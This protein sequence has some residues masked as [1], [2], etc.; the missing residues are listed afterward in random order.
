MTFKDVDDLYARAVELYMAEDYVGA[1]DLVTAGLEQFPQNRR[2]VQGLR[3]M[4]AVRA[5]QQDTSLAILHELIDES[6]GWFG[7][8]FW[9]DEDF[10][11]LRENAEFVRLHA[12]S[13]ERM[14][15]AQAGVKPELTVFE[16]P[17]TSSTP[18]PLLLALHGNSSSVFWHQGHWR[19]A[20][21]RGWLV[22]L[23]QSSQLAG[24]DT[25]D[26]LAYSWDHEPTV[27]REIRDHYAAL[28]GRFAGDRVVIAGFSRGAENAVRLALQGLVPA[29]GFIAVCP[30]GPYSM[31]PELWDMVISAA[32]GRTVRGW[33]IMGGQDHFAEGTNAL[34]DK[35]RAAG[36]AV[37]LSVYDDM[38]HDYPP[39]FQAC[40]P[41]MLAFARG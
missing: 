28:R 24:H 7:G 27:D 26:Q 10:D 41:E 11:A 5:G 30:G 29:R 25:Q 3:A 34:V 31:E 16:P 22:A 20:A 37:E 2:F 18:P 40:L 6:G 14:N 13:D 15:A 21:E 12:L 8:R 33:V 38:G 32:A 19:P 39:D 9:Q 36:L 4:L 23:P 1:F 17:D 35:L